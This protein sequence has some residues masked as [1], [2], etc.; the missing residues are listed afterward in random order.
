METRWK[1]LEK[2]GV[3]RATNEE[4]KEYCSSSEERARACND[5]GFWN[6]KS[7]ELFGLPLKSISALSNTG[8]FMAPV[9]RFRVMA[10]VVETLSTEVKGFSA[11]MYFLRD[12]PDIANHVLVFGLRTMITLP[13]DERAPMSNE[14]IRLLTE[15]INYNDRDLIVDLS[16]QGNDA[17][18]EEIMREFDMEDS[19]NKLYEFAKPQ[20]STTLLLEEK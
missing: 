4:L 3:L 2:K 17:V 9:D 14:A 20:T 1:Q 6:R 10:K 7:I 5:Y 15:R 19:F 12:F 8:G 18:A 11:T 16:Q 13:F